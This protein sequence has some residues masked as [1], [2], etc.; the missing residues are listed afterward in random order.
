MAKK[1]IG[2]VQRVREALATAGVASKIQ[3]LA[4][5]TRSAP[6]A[7]DAVGCAVGQIIKSLVFRGETSSRG[8]LVLV[9]GANRV[10]LVRLVELAG[11][12]VAMADARF[13]REMTGF[14]IGGVPPLG[15][16]EPLTTLVDQDL[17]DWPQ[18]WAAAGA[19]NALFPLTPE[20]LLRITGGTPAEVAEPAA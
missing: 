2:G 3:E 9:S 12:P 7:A 17:L 13:V 6:E 10:S 5:S 1:G 8:Y 15:H 16:R 11:E 20:E 4:D 14:A 19:P 18:L